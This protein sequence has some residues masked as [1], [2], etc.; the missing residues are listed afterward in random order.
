MPDLLARAPT[1]DLRRKWLTQADLGWEP[2]PGERRTGRLDGSNGVSALHFI[3]SPVSSPGTIGRE[4]IWRILCILSSAALDETQMHI[5]SAL[6]LGYSLMDIFS[7][8]S[9]TVAAESG[10]RS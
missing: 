10:N 8:I 3:A 1:S 7:D 4:P 9:E 6:S 2:E 5:R